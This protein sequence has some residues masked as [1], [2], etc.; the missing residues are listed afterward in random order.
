MNIPMIEIL[1]AKDW[2]LQRWTIVGYLLMGAVAIGLLGFGGETAFLAGMILLITV[3]IALGIHVAMAT[4]VTERTEKTLP[5]V[6]SLPISPADYTT[7]KIVANLLIFLVPWTALALGTVTV[8]FGRP[9]VPDG[10]LPYTVL[11]LTE[12]FAAY[13][14]VLSA[15]LITESIGWTIGVMA[16]CNFG[17]QGFIYKV[18][19]LP[20]IAD[21]MKGASVVW[22]GTALG[23]LAAE[24]GTVVVVLV[25]TFWLQSRKTD[26]L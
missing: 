13:C 20:E 8:I 22:S 4:V 1:V 9:D 25:L 10:L 19:R 17:F 2:Y 24:L 12:I 23:I 7:A 26:F 18:S 11:T 15:A 6:M 21:T 5:F 14:L 16:V 3:L